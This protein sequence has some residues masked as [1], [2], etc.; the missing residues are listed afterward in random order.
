M[1]EP[2]E[3]STAASV[4]PNIVKDTSKASDSTQRETNSVPDAIKASIP[5]VRNTLLPKR[6]ALGNPMKQEPSGG[7]GLC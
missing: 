6:D 7:R 2:Y 3:K 4:V 5:G 1:V